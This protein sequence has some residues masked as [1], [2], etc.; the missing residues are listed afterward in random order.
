[1][2]PRLEKKPRRAVSLCP[3]A[4]AGPKSARHRTAP[5]NTATA[6]PALFD[7]LDMFASF[8]LELSNSLR[9]EANGAPPKRG[10][11]GQKR[12]VTPAARIRGSIS[13]S[14]DSGAPDE[15]TV[16][17]SDFK[18]MYFASRLNPT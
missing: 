1:M 10:L 4:F 5:D 3:E 18:G 12:T 11:P 8:L 9:N 15:K 14:T 6:T 17:K 16:V 13:R 2:S 7:N